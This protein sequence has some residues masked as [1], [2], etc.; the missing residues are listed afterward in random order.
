MKPITPMPID[1]PV[2]QMTRPRI[3]SQ[4][5]M[6]V[7]PVYHQYEAAK[8]SR[9]NV[10]IPYDCTIEWVYVN[11][12]DITVSKHD[13]V[14][15]KY[16]Y[17]RDLFLAGDYDILWCV[18]DD[19][20]LPAN[21][22]DTMLEGMHQK[23]AGILYSVYNS[24]HIPSQLNTFTYLRADMGVVITHYLCV[25]NQHDVIPVMGAGMGCTLIRRNVMELIP[26]RLDQ[27]YPGPHQDWW[28]AIDAN[29]LGIPQFC[30]MR[31][32]CNHM[33]D[34]HT[35]IVPDF[36]SLNLYRIMTI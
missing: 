19:M 5:I 6:A 1:I 35:V 3:P 21:I 20:I 26:F 17:A 27:E 25:R 2:W 23:N 31:A 32:H 30:D 33:Q 15:W 8:E 12:P 24:R 22:L 34:E 9:D 10:H 4:K 11:S 29:A 14:L 13:D 16:Q 36:S 28:L 7:V 18:E